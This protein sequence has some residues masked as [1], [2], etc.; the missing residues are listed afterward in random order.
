MFITSYR[1][2]CILLLLITAVTGWASENMAQKFRHDT[3]E[4]GKAALAL[5]RQAM[6]YYCRNREPLPLPATL[7]PLLR[8]RGA[9][10]ISAMDTKGAPRCCMGSLTAKEPTL[11]QE[12]I[13]NACAAVAHDKRFAPI[14]LRELARIRIIVSIIGDSTLVNNPETLNPV[15]DGL[16]IRGVHESGVVLPGETANVGTMLRWGR[17]R[18]GVKADEPIEYFRLDAMRYLEPIIKPMVSE[19]N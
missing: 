6:E 1:Y 15:K 14:T 19:H 16:V 11:A 12:I 2:L 4:Q 18:A 5:G 8:Q 3:L 17:I 7:P 10:F 13:S 9:V